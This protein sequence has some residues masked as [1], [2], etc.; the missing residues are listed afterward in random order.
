MRRFAHLI[1]IVCV[2]AA[3]SVQPSS[4]Q[5]VGPRIDVLRHAVIPYSEDPVNAM[6]TGLA[7]ILPDLMSPSHTET[8][9]GAGMLITHDLGFH[10]ALLGYN[11]RQDQSYRRPDTTYWPLGDVHFRHALIHGYDQLGIISSI[12]GYLVTPVRSL[13][14]PAQSK[15]YNPNVPVHPYNPGD[16]FATAVW[17]PTTGV[18]EDSCSILRYAGYEFTDADTSG[19]VTD[20]DYWQC[21]DGS[22]V[23]N[24]AI[25]TP[26][27]EV[28][29]TSYQH[30]AEFVADLAEIGLA[31]T[32]ANGHH[33][34]INLG[35]DFND[36]MELV[37]DFLDFD[38]FFVAYNLAGLPSHLFRFMHSV[39][40]VRNAGGVDD[41]TIDALTE[42][43]KYSLDS[44]EIEAAAKQVQTMVYAHTDPNMYPNCHHYAL[45]YMTLYSRTFFNAFAEYAGGIVKSPGYGSGNRWTLLNIHWKSGY[46]RVEEEKTVV[47]YVNGDEPDVFNPCS[48]TT[49]YEW[50]IIDS[51]L[52]RL[53]AVNPYNH[54]DVPWLATDWTI[55]ET[56][57]G[58]EI[59][60]T[61]RD[62]LYWQDGYPFTAYDV[63]FCLEFLRDQHVP[64]YEEAWW[65]LEDVVVTNDTH[66]SIVTSWEGLDLFYDYT[67]LAAMLP[68]QIWNRTWASDQAILDYDPTVHAYGTDMAPNYAPGPWASEV[69]TNLFGTSP[70]IF[71]FYDAVHLYDDLWRN[72][73]YF[74]TT[75]AIHD[76]LVE[77][78]WEVGD[79]NRDGI[80][81]V[82]D[83]TYVSQ[84][85]GG[86]WIPPPFPPDPLYDP[87]AD[88][89]RD[90]VIDMRDI[91]IQA[92]HL[93]W[94]REYGDP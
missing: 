28:A 78:F 38:A 58:M 40:G 91:S 73:H 45:G 64:R 82:I 6:L 23:P 68:P 34:M 77:M 19:T 25:F 55:A 10:I 27:M 15:Y 87:P 18:N 7:D 2:L 85:F 30:I 69:P 21:P 31:A 94:Q 56:A 59:T 41:P 26:L 51:T 13:V 29:P 93:L 17:D 1:L 75:E 76:L 61:L 65:P 52:D 47:I 90:G 79:A 24:M 86:I 16:P 72:E 35:W 32:A 71:Q 4:A 92:Y 60:F 48:A 67:R 54:R 53:T 9:D 39:L 8:L 43:V 5:E 74:L 3:L 57:G 14:P 22:L 20:A 62:D 70:W 11:I 83:L 80:V 36:Y 44:N 89:N 50:N 12:Y 84:R 81:N 33:G 46:E 66:L 49:E 42:T 88:F 37:Y 63:E